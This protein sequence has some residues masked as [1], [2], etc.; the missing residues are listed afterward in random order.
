MEISWLGHSCFRIKSK[1]A[2][3]ITDPYDKSVGYQMG[4]VS[5][6][7][8]TVSHDHF[9]HNNAAAIGGDPKI[10]KGPGEYEIKG[11]MITG[12]RTFHDSEGGKKRGKNTVYLIEADDL[13]VC[14]LGDLGQVLSAE[15]AEEMNNADILMVP[16]GGNYTIN[17]AQAAEV[18]SLIEPKIVIPMHYKTDV[19]KLEIDPVD[20]FCREMG[21]KSPQPQPKLVINRSSLPAESQVVLLDYRKGS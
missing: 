6:D 5:A 15:Q 14:H 3:I 9:D 20:K 18:I 8:V 1:D 12:V 4:R 13:V 16:V 19:V 10:V 17:T 7:I 11:V 2:T 21:I